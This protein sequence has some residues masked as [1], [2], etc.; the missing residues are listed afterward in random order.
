M[1]VLCTATQ[2]AGTEDDLATDVVASKLAEVKANDAEAPAAEPEVKD[3]A[4]V[5]VYD[6]EKEFANKHNCS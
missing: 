2:G 4:G 5:A 6:S 1:I 3:A